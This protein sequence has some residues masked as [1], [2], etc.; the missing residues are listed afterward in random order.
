MAVLQGMFQLIIT[1]AMFILVLDDD[2]D[3]GTVDFATK[4]ATIL[5]DILC[6]PKL[7]LSTKVGPPLPQHSSPAMSR[8]PS[9]LS[10]R[11]NSALK[12]SVV[13]ELWTVVRTTFPNNLL[14]PAG[15]RLLACLREDEADLVWETDS[16]DDARKQW[17]YLCAE[18]L[19]ICEV[20][21]LREFWAKRSSA[22]AMMSYEPGVQ[23]LV[24]GCF[25]E[26]WTEDTEG[27]WEGAA[28]LLGVPFG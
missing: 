23:S 12:L 14:Q 25:I 19:V 7:D 26:K 3:A 9:L 20:D 28:L 5:V 4:A 16:P 6:D 13:R 1:C 27:P 18:V 11:S 24:W 2:D 8:K 17:A 15:A 21:S 10:S 22:M